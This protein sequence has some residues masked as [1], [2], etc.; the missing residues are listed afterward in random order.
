[1]LAG[2]AGAV[3]VSARTGCC[4]RPA[5]GGAAKPMQ[6]FHLSNSYLAFVFVAVAI[7]TFVR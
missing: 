4:G 7:D 2:V 6:F 5:R 1:M 3:L